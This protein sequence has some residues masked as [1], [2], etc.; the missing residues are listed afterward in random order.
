MTNT[1]DLLQRA[2]YASSLKQKVI[3]NNIAN[4]TTPNFKPDRVEFSQFLQE[5][6]AKSSFTG[7]RTNPQHV[8]IG[9]L[10]NRE[11]I[12]VKQPVVMKNGGNGVDMDYEM[13][14]MT[15]NNVWYQALTNQINE[16]FNYIK[17]AIKG[18]G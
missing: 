14:E 2:L 11:P 8:P 17:I 18:R 10:N 5:E 15:K 9:V 16:E 7:T 1:I 4:V 12:I 13:S 3:S 6:L